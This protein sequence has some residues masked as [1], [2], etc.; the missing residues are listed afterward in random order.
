[1]CHLDVEQA[2][3][4]GE[5]GE[6]LAECFLCKSW[7]SAHSMTGREMFFRAAAGMRIALAD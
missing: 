7:N 5:Q 1:M 3:R 2:S 6:Y 4:T